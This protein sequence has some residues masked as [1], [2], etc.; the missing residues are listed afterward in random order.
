MKTIAAA[1]IKIAVLIGVKEQ[2][3]L[4]PSLHALLTSA[5]GNT[6]LIAEIA[7]R[8]IAIATANVLGFIFV[9]SPPLVSLTLSVPD[10]F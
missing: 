6:V 8:K 5:L 3:A 10:L 2:A 4:Y 1:I 9:F 7:K